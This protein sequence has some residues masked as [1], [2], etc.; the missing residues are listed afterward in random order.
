SGLKTLNDAINEK[1]DWQARR[2][3]KTSALTL[4]KLE[5]MMSF[6]MAKGLVAQKAGPHY[7]APMTAVIAIEQ[8]AGFNRAEALDIERKHFVKLAKSEEAKSLV[9]LFLNDQYIKGLAK[10]AAKSANKDTSRAAV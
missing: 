9:G 6:T 10:K 3:Q 7:P 4:S 8:G 5:S 2:Q 1:L